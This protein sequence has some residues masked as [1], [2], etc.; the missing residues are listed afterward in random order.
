MGACTICHRDKELRPY[1]IGGARICFDCMK[2]DPALE[3]NAKGVLGKQL[4]AAEHMVL[5]ERGI[6]PAQ[7]N[8]HAV[9]VLKGLGISVDRWKPS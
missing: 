4:N 9:K 2:A 5:D 8:P 6:Y 1:G 7:H 3:A